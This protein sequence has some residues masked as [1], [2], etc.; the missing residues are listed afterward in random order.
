MHAALEDFIETYTCVAHPNEIKFAHSSGSNFNAENIEAVIL[1]ALE[2][3]PATY[4]VS[5]TGNFNDPGVGFGQ[6]VG[7]SNVEVYVENTV[8]GE[9]TATYTINVSSR[10]LNKVIT[11]MALYAC[12]EE[13]ELWKPIENTLSAYLCSQHEDDG[14][15]WTVLHFVF[16]D[17]ASF[18][19]ENFEAAIR[20]AIGTEDGTIV[21]SK[22]DPERLD[23][24]RA[25]RFYVYEW[26]GKVLEL[27]Q[28]FDCLCSTDA[29]VTE[30]QIS[31]HPTP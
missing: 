14:D 12:H 27:T 7:A 17:A 29:T 5:V 3:D 23:Q 11:T 26:N 22:Y 31:T 1:D 4:S 2:L 16:P 6:D 9:T 24:E 28:E 13:S 18:T 10:K 30:A 25:N 8:T 19:Q 21:I 15:P 20:A